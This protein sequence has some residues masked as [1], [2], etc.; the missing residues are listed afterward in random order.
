[1][2]TRATIYYTIWESPLQLIIMTSDGEALTGLYLSEQAQAEI[3]RQA[4]N[5]SQA[6]AQNAVQPSSPNS[7]QWIRSD[8]A[9]PFADVKRQ[10]T[11]YFAGRQTTFDVPLKPQGTPFQQQVWEEL[12]RI[13][14][15]ATISYGELARRIGNPNA[16]RAVGLANGRNPVSILVPCHRVIG[17][18]GKLTGYSGGLSRKETL[19]ALERKILENLSALK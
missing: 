18:N 2:T 12:R 1:M 10:L 17:T 15:G 11:A 13:P 5:T 7:T 19:L 3:K 14:F 4:E 6:A 8:E 16:S 9:A